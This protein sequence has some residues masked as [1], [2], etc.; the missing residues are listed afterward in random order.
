MSDRPA[1]TT[2]QPIALDAKGICSG[3]F[4]VSLRQW[5]AWDSAGLVPRGFRVAGSTR[6]WWRWSDLDAWARLGF[7]DRTTFE[8]QPF[9]VQ[10]AQKRRQEGV[11]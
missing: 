10:A 5:R 6:K 3:I 8:Q 2:A 4:P 11:A 9:E 7:P 1:N